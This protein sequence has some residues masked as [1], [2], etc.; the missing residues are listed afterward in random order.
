MSTLNFS[1]EQLLHT[2]TEIVNAEAK[3][4]TLEVNQSLNLFSK[5]QARMD[6]SPN[7]SVQSITVA[8]DVLLNYMQQG[9]FG[10]LGRMVQLFVEDNGLEDDEMIGMHVCSIIDHH[11]QQVVGGL[12]WVVVQMLR[13]AHLKGVDLS[14]LLTALTTYKR[15][16]VTL[17]DGGLVGNW[18]PTHEF[19]KN[20]DDG[21]TS[22]PVS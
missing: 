19:P 8:A 9:W 22:V 5:T 3:R 21:T 17:N 18:L 1:E 6:V 11:V 13:E 7:V 12:C 16:G 20:D 10:G 14:P 15:P 2:A 4:L